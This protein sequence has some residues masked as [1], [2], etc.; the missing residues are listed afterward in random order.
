MLAYVKVR[1]KQFSDAWVLFCLKLWHVVHSVTYWKELVLNYNM[2]Q[3]VKK[4][5]LPLYAK[6]FDNEWYMLQYSITQLF[7]HVRINPCP[8]FYS[9]NIKSF[10]STCFLDS[11]KLLLCLMQSF[12]LRT[13]DTC[14]FG[15]GNYKRCYLRLP[16]FWGR[17]DLSDCMV[18]ICPNS[19]SRFVWFH[20][21]S[22]RVSSVQ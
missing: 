19:L 17:E 8:H 2:V 6:P 3:Y 5:L 18:R 4:G 11:F 7:P 16:A 12:V 10:C 9:L 15:Q 13:E 20:Q 1:N 22:N 14:V 21:E